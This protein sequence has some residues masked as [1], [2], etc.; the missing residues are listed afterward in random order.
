MPACNLERWKK[1]FNGRYFFSWFFVARAN[2]KIRILALGRGSTL[3]TQFENR[4]AIVGNFKVAVSPTR[5]DFAF[6][7]RLRLRCGCP[8][9]I[10][11]SYSYVLYLRPSPAAARV[12]LAGAPPVR[13]RLRIDRLSFNKK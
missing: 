2:Q 6:L 12:T 10:G 4:L 9:I 8:M 13:L 11:T 3:E 7:P 5:L 1:K